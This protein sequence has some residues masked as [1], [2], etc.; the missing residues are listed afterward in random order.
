MNV[1]HI[2]DKDTTRTRAT[3][4][5]KEYEERPTSYTVLP[6]NAIFIQEFLDNA[7]PIVNKASS[8]Y[9]MSLSSDNDTIFKNTTHTIVLSLVAIS[10]KNDKVIKPLLNQ[11]P[12]LPYPPRLISS[13]H[14]SSTNR[15]WTVLFMLLQVFM[16]M[17][18]A[19]KN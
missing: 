11:S 18:T 8:K 13:P 12:I 15:I 9:Y 3:D 6:K 19:M 5:D 16:R 2:T 7:I 4:H 17:P 14:P 1:K 10:N